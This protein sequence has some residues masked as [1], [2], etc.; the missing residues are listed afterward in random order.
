MRHRRHGIHRLAPCGCA[1]ARGA[2]V[3]VIDDLSNASLEN[4]RDVRSRITFVLGSI[5]DPHALHAVTDRALV[6]FH[7][8]A[9]GRCCAAWRSRLRFIQVN[10]MGTLAMLEAAR[11][12]LRR[13][14]PCRT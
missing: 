10:A 4:L 2:I 7:Q 11:K 3:S 14:E 12:T 13:C 9:L 6:I 1:V 5:L 8:A